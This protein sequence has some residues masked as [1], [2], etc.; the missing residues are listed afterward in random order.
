MFIYHVYECVR[1]YMYTSRQ[2][3]FRCIFYNIVYILWNISEGRQLGW[4]EKCGLSVILTGW[5][6]WCAACHDQKLADI[7]VLP[8]AA[9]ARTGRNTNIPLQYLMWRIST[10]YQ[11]L[12]LTDYSGLHARLCVIWSIKA[13][14][15][16]HIV[17]TEKIWYFFNLFCKMWKSSIFDSLTRPCV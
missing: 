14:F 8:H 6:Q 5:R 1:F 7:Y 9:G 13:V 11:L 12:F 3:I 4:C 15:W 17:K 16:S 10:F 2:C